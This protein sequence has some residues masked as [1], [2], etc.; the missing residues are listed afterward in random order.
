MAYRVRVDNAEIEIRS[1]LLSVLS[2]LET[3]GDAMRDVD[4]MR[5]AGA[6]QAMQQ[7][8]AEIVPPSKAL[9]PSRGTAESATTAARTLCDPDSG[10]PWQSVGRSRAQVKSI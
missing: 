4:D 3:E 9:A 1:R 6:L 8:K 5:V 2:V 10:R 7:T